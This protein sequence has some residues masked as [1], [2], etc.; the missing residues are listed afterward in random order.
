MRQQLALP[1]DWVGDVWH[2]DNRG[3]THATHRH[4]ELEFNL[5]TRGAGAYLLAHRKYEIRRG[6]LVWL[7]PG[8][9]HVLLEQ[10]LDFQMWIGVFKPALVRRVA[11]DPAA[12]ILRQANPPGEYCRR[13]GGR[14]FDRLDALCAEVEASHDRPGLFNAGLGYVLANAW[15]SF[16]GAAEVSVPNVHPAVEKAAQFIRDE[17]T[18]IGLAELAGRCGLSASRLSRLFKQQT[19]VALVDFRN[20][21]RVERF[22]RLRENGRLKLIDAAL[23]A[24]FGSYPQFHRVF[25]RV[26]GCSP[27]AYRRADLEAVSPDPANRAAGHTA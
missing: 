5:V 7:F 27:G 9:E 2:Y 13:L 16:Q 3:R 20:R 10:T 18:T 26:L 8:Q 21:Q 19:G 6:D 15:Q 4:V 23:E 11:S 14:A 1:K 17:S 12:R 25:K 24:G 22:L